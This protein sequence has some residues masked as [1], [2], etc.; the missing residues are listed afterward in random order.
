LDGAAGAESALAHILVIDDA[1]LVRDVL[2]QFLSRAGHRV[3]EAEDGAEAVAVYGA[4]PADL[5]ICDLVMPNMDGLETLRALRRLDPAARVIMISG[6]MPEHT[7]D[8]IEA[9]RALGAID[10]LAKPFARAM[11]IETVAAALAGTESS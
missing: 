7:A 4:E 8:S 3:S 1:K 9:A 2:R 5:V 10:F 6:G 11:L